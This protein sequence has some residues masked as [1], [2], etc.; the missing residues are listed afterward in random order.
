MDIVLLAKLIEIPEED[1]EDESG[2]LP[3]CKFEVTEVLNGEAWYAAGDPIEVHYFGAGSDGTFLIMGTDPPQT[4]WGTPLVISDRA[5]DYLKELPLLPADAERLQFFIQFLEDEDELLARDAYD[6]FAKTPYEGVIALKDSMDHD[7][8][9]D[10]IKNPDVPPSRRRLYLT[11][12]GVCG[13]KDDCDMLEEMMRSDD[14]D[15]KAGLNALIACYLSLAGADG[16]PV[17]EELFLANPDAEYAD[18]Y[19]AIMALRFHGNDHDLISREKLLP[20]MRAVL[21]RADLADLVIPDLA[22]WEDWDVMPRLVEL[23]KNADEE[24]NWVRVPVVNYL[25]AC[26]NEEAKTAIEDLKKIDPEAVQRAE[27]FF[28]FT[29]F[30]GEKRGDDST[31]DDPTTMPEEDDLLAARQSVAPKMRPRDRTIYDYKPPEEPGFNW[32]PTAFF[33]GLLVLALLIKLATSGATA[34]AAAHPISTNGQLNGKPAQ[35]TT[36]KSTGEK[37]V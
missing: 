9:V 21:A 4:M 24:S 30:A 36:A 6:E 26:P 10:W 33:G 31:D 29:Q 7:Q 1:E 27:S 11:M 5:Q 18:T 16:L 12:L 28:P 25:R 34:K 35:D 19:A 32:M 22:R 13:N 17:V 15:Q 14:R 2:E 3:K 20:G 37:T 8:L 23:F